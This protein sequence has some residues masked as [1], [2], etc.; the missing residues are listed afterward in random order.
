[1]GYDS[2]SWDSAHDIRPLQNS[3]WVIS[4]QAVCNKPLFGVSRASVLN[5][6]SF[7]I[8]SKMGWAISQQ[9]LANW[10]VISQRIDLVG[11][12]P[13]VCDKPVR[14]RIGG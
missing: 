4:Q 11:D 8:H 12:K 9:N 5:L 2:K 13:L 10:W 3:R 6:L 1:M 14:K 7:L